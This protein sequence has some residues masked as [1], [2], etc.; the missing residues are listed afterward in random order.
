LANVVERAV[1]LTTNGYLTPDHLLLGRENF[2]G[3]RHKL[4]PLNEAKEEFERAY[5]LQVLTAT[6]GNVSR[7]ASLAGRY[8]AEFYKLLRKYEL[9]PDAF[10]TENAE[11]ENLNG[12]PS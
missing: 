6:R 5:L 4:L 1:A 12:F 8:R 10:R 9:D 7:A 11:T 3:S 2:R